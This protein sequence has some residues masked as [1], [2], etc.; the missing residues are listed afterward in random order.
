MRIFRSI[1]RSAK[2]AAFFVIPAL[3][4]SCDFEYDLPEEGS[5]PDATPPMANFAF[6]QGDGENWNTYS[7]ANLSMSATDYEWDFGDGNTSTEHDPQNTYSGEGTFTVSLKAMDKLGAESV[8]SS[9]VVVVEPEAP[10]ATIPVILEPSFEDLSLPDG[11]GDGRDSWRNDFGGVIQITSSPV[12]DGSQAAKFPSAGDRV[13]YQDGL[14]VTPNTDYILT[15]YY[16][17]KTDNP[18]SITLT[19]LGGS[20][21]DLSEVEGATLAAFEGTDQSDSGTYVKVDL[22]FNSGANE[23]MSILIMNQGVE[24]RLDNLSIDLADPGL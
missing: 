15:Y 10:T 11:T 14:Q 7:F 18:G 24:A 19:V 17:L 2:L 4:S 20:I 8:F 16:T 3:L 6:T 22:L 5:I 13:A 12:Q 23:T 21:A 9:E 1:Q